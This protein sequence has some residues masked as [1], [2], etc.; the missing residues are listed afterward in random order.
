VSYHQ[1]KATKTSKSNSK[2]PSVDR[3]VVNMSFQSQS[4]QA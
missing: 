1:N 4:H 3:R 2:I